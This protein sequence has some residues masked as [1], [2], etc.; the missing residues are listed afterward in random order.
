MI[1]M[2]VMQMAVHQVANVVAMGHGF[3]AATR[4]VY[5]SFLVRAA[6]VVRRAALGI[7]I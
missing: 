6:V 3:V 4:S 1:A 7:C 5:M 2:R